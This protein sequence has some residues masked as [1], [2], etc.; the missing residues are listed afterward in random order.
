MP[1]LSMHRRVFLFA[2]SAMIAAAAFVAT[3]AFAQSRQETLLVLVENGPNS[4]DI[5]GVG[6]SFRS[7]VAAW[8]MYDRLVTFGRKALPDGT[9]TYDY[10]KIEPELAESYS[11]APDGASI[12]FKLRKDAKFHDGTPVTAKDVKWSYDRAVSVGGFP[13]FQM[14]AGSLTKPEQFVA[15]DDYTFR[16]DLPKKDKLSLPDMAVVVPAIFNSTLAKKNAT[17]KDPWAMEWMKTNSAAGG[18]YKLDKWTPGQEIT[19]N[20]N[21]DWKGGPL[22]KIKRVIIRE[23]PSSG[24]R[25]A[26]MERGDA[27]ISV[28]MPQKDA[29]EILAEKGSGKY[30]VVGVP[31]ENSLKYIGMVTTQKPFDNVK[32]RQAVAHVVPYEQ[33]YKSAIYGRGIPM[34]LGPAD[35]PKDA[36]WPQPFPYKT[37]LAKAKQLLTEAGYPD[38]FETTISIDLGDATASEPEAVLLQEAL[39]KIGIKATIEKIPGANFRNAMLQKNRPIHIASFGGWLNFPDYY[40]FWG[41]HGQ[42]AVF[43]TMA[44]KDAKMDALIDASRYETDPAKYKGQVMGFIKQAMDEAPRIPL[45]QQILDVGMQKNIKGY[46]YWFHRQLDFRQIE[47]L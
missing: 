44:Y 34:A 16:V 26:L 9:M 8:N 28:D 32:V 43:N 25:R 22:P 3:P 40:F 6:T 33:I 39:G 30:L 5:H 20:R 19:F 31:I 47:K 17:E 10:S 35:A 4:L 46:T 14:A 37:D 23:V 24:N 15:V 11:V 1:Q 7:Y 29:A 12:T 2:S 27:D 18:A 13:T 21:D 38:G 41:Y 42:N 45:Y 36:S